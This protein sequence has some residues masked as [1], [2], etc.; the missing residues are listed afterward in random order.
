M[1][2]IKDLDAKV[3]THF[4]ERSERH[5]DARA[6]WL[7]KDLF[8]RLDSS[9]PDYASVARSVHHMKGEPASEQSMQ[10]MQGM[11]ATAYPGSAGTKPNQQMRLQAISEITDAA[12]TGAYGREMG[13]L[14]RLN[15]A[16]A[17]TET[18]DRLTQAGAY[19]LMGGGATMGLTAAGQGLIA[20]TQ[21]IQGSK[22]VEQERQQPLG[23]G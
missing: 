13:P 1:K 7:K 17:G 15:R 8:E 19:G 21:M 4:K 20:L 18:G 23:A 9:N 6:D 10:V 11:F 3:R 2:F 5:G 12:E 14:T 22:Q 16:M